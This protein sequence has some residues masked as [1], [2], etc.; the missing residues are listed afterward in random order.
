MKGGGGVINYY[1]W[2]NPQRRQ[3]GENVK[4]RRQGKMEIKF[5]LTS[6]PANPE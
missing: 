6:N 2:E 5:S 3:R 1:L 4:D